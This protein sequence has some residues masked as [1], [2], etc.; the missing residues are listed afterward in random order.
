MSLRIEKAKEAD[1]LILDIPEDTKILE[2][3][4]L[5]FEKGRAR[6]GITVLGW[7]AFERRNARVKAKMETGKA[8]PTY[9]IY[10]NDRT[11]LGRA[12]GDMLRYL[13]AYCPNN[14]PETYNTL[15]RIA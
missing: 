8:A 11:E 14:D 15:S 3:D 1:Q 4:I 2:G 5:T 9:F 6:D 10:K 13:W 12:K 7:P